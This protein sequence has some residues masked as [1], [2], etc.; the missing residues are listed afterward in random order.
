MTKYLCYSSITLVMLM[1]LTQNAYAEPEA[2][3][4]KSKNNASVAPS[5]SPAITLPSTAAAAVEGNVIASLPRDV[6]I[7]ERFRTYSG[8]RTPTALSDLFTAPVSSRIR[9]QPEI[10]LSSGAVS[11]SITL[12][13]STQESSA[14]NFAINGAQLLSQ[15]Q[16]QKGEWLIEAL[17]ET[18]TWKA[19]LIVL[20]NSTTLEFPL[21]VA[22]PLPAETDLTEKGF[23]AF[24]GGREPAA[25]PLRDLNDDGRRDYLD[26]YIFTANYLVRKNSGVPDPAGESPATIEEQMGG[27]GYNPQEPV[28]GTSPDAQRPAPA[29]DTVTQPAADGQAGNPAANNSSTPTDLT[30]DRKTYNSLTYDQK[31]R[32]REERARKNKLNSTP[33]GQ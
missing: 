32:L 19:D 3:I 6:S 20:N 14:P 33:Q 7:L 8:K 12:M 29:R 9:Q 22:P 23:I 1:L 31:K 11:V 5:L 16:N 2:S 13:L 10:A 15:R 30:I 26:E 17:L 28:A 25:E 24:L 21:V 4:I 18:G 27:Q